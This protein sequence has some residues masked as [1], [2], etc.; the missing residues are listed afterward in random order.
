MTPFLPALAGALLVAGAL[1]LVQAWRKHPPRPPR[2]QRTP[3][4]FGP[5]LD[6][7]SRRL[8]L[9]GLAAGLIIALVTGWVAAVVVIPAVLL[10]LPY[11]L[12]A[13]PA[14]AEVRRLEAMEEWV[15]SVAGVLTAGV[16]LE[17]A[18]VTSLRSTPEQI[19]PEVSRLV[20]RIRARWGTVE[21]L[22]IF[23]DELND[24]TGDLIAANLILG[25]KRRG[26]GLATVLEALAESVGHD[27]RARREIE[28]DRA[29]PR[30]NARLITIISVAVLGLLA[31]SGDYVAPYGWP[32]GQALLIVLLALYAAALLWMRK[33]AQGKPM[34]RF[35]GQSV[36]DEEAVAA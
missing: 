29:K 16:G 35:I 22:R 34:P 27:V 25:A 30:S 17:Q 19:R 3:R 23:A 24:P 5:T 10:G 9:I 12:S 11:L 36:R 13:P 26:A 21:A 32:F 7:R 2:P 20:G 4:K 31:F 6:R 33:M 14:D 15:R 8:L 18:I 1:V 28:A